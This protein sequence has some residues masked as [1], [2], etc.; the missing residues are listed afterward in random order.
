M[1]RFRDR[2]KKMAGEL[3]RS[4]RYISNLR[5]FEALGLRSYM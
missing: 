3:Y 1:L 4:K 5:S 2:S